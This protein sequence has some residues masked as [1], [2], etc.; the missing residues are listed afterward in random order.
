MTSRDMADIPFSRAWIELLK[1]RAA[2]ESSTT[3]EEITDIIRVGARSIVGA[4]GICFVRR[5]GD[6]CLYVAEDAI[7]PLWLG[8]TF[9]MP[10][11]IS[12]W[13]MLNNQPAIIE[14]IHSD[15]RIPAE[16]YKDTFV[17]SL[18]MVPVVVAG[19]PVAAL[20]SYWSREGT[21]AKET[22]FYMQVLVSAIERAMLRI[23]QPLEPMEG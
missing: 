8:Q 6:N 9:P 19:Q 1:T 3:V 16:L 4:D 21:P 23:S 20:G 14:D 7:A 13:C 5:V 17:S 11:C 12:G 18:A 10:A 15:A 22:V 2:L